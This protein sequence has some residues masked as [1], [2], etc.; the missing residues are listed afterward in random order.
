VDKP[1]AHAVYDTT[2][3]TM[4][5]AETLSWQ[6]QDRWGTS[7]FEM[8]CTYRIWLKKPNYAR[9]EATRDGEVAGVLV[10]DDE[11]CWIYWPNGRV[12]Y[13]FEDEATYERTRLISYMQMEAPA[14]R[15]SL[16]H[17]TGMLGGGMGMPVL[18]PSYFHGGGSS[19]DEY[20][21]GVR[22]LGTD[23]V[24]DEECDLI[25]VSFMDNQRSKYLWISP[26]NHLPRKLKE[27]VRVERDI[28]KDEL[29]S[30]VM[31]DEPLAD[32]MF[33]W[34]PPEG[35]VEWQLPNIEDGVLKNGT[36]APDFDLP[37]TEGSRIRLSDYRGKVVW[38]CFWRVGCPSCR[39]EMPVLEELHRE[40]GRKGVAVIGIDAVDEA[41][42][43][44]ALLRDCG[45]TFTNVID[46][47]EAAH[48]A[49]FTDYQTLPGMS[50]VPLYYVIDRD[51]KVVDGFYDLDA[52]RGRAALRTAGVV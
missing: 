49:V 19:L 33:K 42:I 21:D 45:V 43:A 28:I 20:L 44:K 46:T 12:R 47:S 2:L 8:S 29:W 14:G 15:F 11:Y 35:W 22:G 7:E 34:S 4:R 6:S 38:L 52:E 24:G 27:V 41:D 39:E 36:V 23:K 5:K 17:Q 3:D 32:E 1:A 18:Q 50:G 40:Y 10:L 37:G 9:I 13:D 31:V 25:E 30:E 51:G 26:R 48:K 16:S